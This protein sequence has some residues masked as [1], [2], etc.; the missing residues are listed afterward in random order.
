MET[1]KSRLGKH[2]K[3]NFTCPRSLRSEKIKQGQISGPTKFLAQPKR[4]S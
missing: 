2:S 3:Q 4:R 1:L